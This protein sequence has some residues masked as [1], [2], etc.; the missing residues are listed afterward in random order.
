MH[1]GPPT[2]CGC[3]PRG[4]NT[5]GVTRSIAPLWRNRNLQKTSEQLTKIRVSP[6]TTKTKREAQLATHRTGIAHARAKCNAR[7]SVAPM[8]PKAR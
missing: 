3:E 6:T 5:W 4:A 7:P 2:L 8:S 1:C